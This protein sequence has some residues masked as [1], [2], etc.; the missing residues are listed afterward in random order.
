MRNIHTIIFSMKNIEAKR[1][2]VFLGFFYIE[3]K[4]KHYIS[5]KELSLSFNPSKEEINALFDIISENTNKSKTVPVYILNKSSIKTIL[6]TRSQLFS[7]NYIS[8]EK[9][10]I[11]CLYCLEQNKHK[12]LDY[13]KENNHFNLYTNISVHYEKNERK[14]QTYFKISSFFS[15]EEATKNNKP[16]KVEKKGITHTKNDAQII[17]FNFIKDHINSLGLNLKNLYINN[18]YNDMN[19][20][21]PI[22]KYIK[23]KD[24]HNLKNLHFIYEKFKKPL[25][26]DTEIKEM[27][28]KMDNFLKEKSDSN[29]FTVIYTD[30]SSFEDKYSAACL[31]ENGNRKFEKVVS[32][33]AKEE[34][35]NNSNY[36]ELVAIYTALDIVFKNNLL[37]KPLSFV[38]DSD[39]ISINLRWIKEKRYDLVDK[40]L[41]KSSLFRK[42]YKMLNYFDFNYVLTTVKS[43]TNNKMDLYL[44]NKIVDEMANKALKS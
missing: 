28:A 3:N 44:K 22:K 34:V 42:I 11:G 33:K 39:F 18:R 30:G 26:M 32:N 41:K 16:F 23:L 4:V 25:I 20:Y 21:F 15:K 24:I 37:D 43:H 6:D 12:D 36:S 31:I 7:F 1:I 13:F 38:L 17:L 2:N 8:V 9:N 29:K 40:N 5:R 10:I 27:R 19:T 14:K 35:K